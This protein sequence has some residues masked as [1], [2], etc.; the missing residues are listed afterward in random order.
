MVSYL[1]RMPSGIVG[2]ITRT[3]GSA[4]EP[5]QLTPSGTTGAPTAYGVP[6][7]ID[8]GTGNARTVTAADTAIFGI[9]VRPFP[10]NAGTDALGV[11]TPPGAVGSAGDAMRRGYMSVILSGATAAVKGQPVYIWTAAATGT[12]II[13]GY[14]STNPGSSG[15]V[16][17]NT[18]FEGPAD[19]SGIVEIAYNT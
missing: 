3:N 6:L 7:V 14:E 11:G 10:T 8:S 4:I 5:V 1:F 19:A 18:V 13:G 17:P 2:D 9:L 12:H 15:F 16:L